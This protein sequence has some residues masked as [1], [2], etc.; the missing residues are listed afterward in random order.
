MTELMIVEIVPMNRPTVVS[1][2]ADSYI[3]F[4]VIG[5]PYGFRFVVTSTASQ[6]VR[7]SSRAMKLGMRL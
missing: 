5:T 1:N 7:I 3:Y 2:V 4:P 6:S